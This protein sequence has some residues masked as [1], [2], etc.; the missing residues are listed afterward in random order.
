MTT[1]LS[2]NERY[3]IIRKIKEGKHNIL[4]SDCMTDN[5]NV[6]V[7]FHTIFHFTQRGIIITLDRSNVVISQNIIH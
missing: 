5:I 2:T 7:S 3:E 6:T 4:Q 1:Y